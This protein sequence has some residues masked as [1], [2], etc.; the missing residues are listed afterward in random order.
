MAVEIEVVIDEPPLTE[1]TIESGLMT[2]AQAINHTTPVR[3]DNT[4]E[5]PVQPIALNG[6]L[7]EPSPAMAFI[8]KP[9]HLGVTV[10]LDLDA[11]LH[12]EKGVGLG[13]RCHFRSSGVFIPRGK[14]LPFV[15]PRTV[16]KK[17]FDSP[18]K[19]ASLG[20]PVPVSCAAHGSV[21]L[22]DLPEFDGAIVRH[23]TGTS[24]RLEG[25]IGLQPLF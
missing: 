2:S 4:S 24:E 12:G 5:P 7:N 22:S 21:S 20:W 16:R 9:D 18:V 13:F 10:V 23:L 11:R 8:V 14:P 15:D 25:H 17:A 1:R 19:S 6:S 3:M